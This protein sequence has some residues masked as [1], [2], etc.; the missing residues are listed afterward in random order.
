MLLPLN[1]EHMEHHLRNMNQL[2]R[3]NTNLLLPYMN[4]LHL[5]MTLPE[6]PGDSATEEITEDNKEVE[7]ADEGEEDEEV[8]DVVEAKPSSPEEH[9]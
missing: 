6:M 9:G 3:L 5:P 7:E 8:E 4:Q 2:H 1:R